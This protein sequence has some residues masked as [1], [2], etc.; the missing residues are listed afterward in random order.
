MC[1]DLST[2][3]QTKNPFYSV[4]AAEISEGDDLNADDCQYKDKILEH[5]ANALVNATL[6][7]IKEEQQI[8]NITC[9]LQ[10]S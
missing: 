1:Q 5:T 6:D 10:Y 2:P 3:V 9:K 8:S 7:E 4:L